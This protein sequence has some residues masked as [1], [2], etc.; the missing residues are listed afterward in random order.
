MDDS[1]LGDASAPA[2]AQPEEDGDRHARGE[3]GEE[4]DAGLADDRAS[5]SAG[6]DTDRE[7]EACGL[8]GAGA[9]R[10]EGAFGRK[11]GHTQF[12][13]EFSREGFYLVNLSSSITLRGFETPE[14]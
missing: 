1:V 13:P 14:R 2:L 11:A 3:A 6:E 12:L 7:Y 8:G 4:A 5:D 9:L 10:H